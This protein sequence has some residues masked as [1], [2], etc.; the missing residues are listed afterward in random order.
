MFDVFETGSGQ[1]YHSSLL[2]HCDKNF[3]TGTATSVI[4]F[5]VFIHSLKIL[6]LDQKCTCCGG[7]MVARIKHA[8]Q[9][10]TALQVELRYIGTE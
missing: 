6:H 9:S 3:S 10:F 4:E 5:G 2:W 7:G 8:E 1:P